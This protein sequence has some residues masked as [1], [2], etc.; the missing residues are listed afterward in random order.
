MRWGSRPSLR[1]L[2]PRS[3]IERKTPEV[4]SAPHDNLTTTMRDTPK[5]I[6]QQT[7]LGSQTNQPSA[8]PS[9]GLG[10]VQHTHAI[11]RPITER[12]LRHWIERLTPGLVRLSYA[13]CRDR[14]RAEELV[15]E[16]FVRLWRSPP[17]AG[18]PAIASWMRSTVTNLSISAI[19]RKRRDWTLIDESGTARD[20]RAEMPGRAGERREDLS[21]IAAALERLDPDK[22]AMIMLR[23]NEGLSYEAIA[24]HLGVPIG[25]VMSRLNRAR[26]ALLGELG[27]QEAVNEQPI[28]PSEFRV[29][30]MDSETT[31]ARRPEQRKSREA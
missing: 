8:S 19:R 4:R 3:V 14:H 7:T 5:D 2:A 1:S 26:L 21:R 9:A 28:R 31:S 15:Q 12:V 29:E 20:L 17:D 22:R 11:H 27:G 10:E 30:R 23:V 16:A 25:T 13:I 18:E 6:P 24:N